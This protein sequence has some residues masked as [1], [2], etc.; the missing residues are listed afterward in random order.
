MVLKC[1]P[2]DTKTSL[3]KLLWKKLQKPQQNPK[4]S[5]IQNLMPRGSESNP[6]L[7]L[8]K[9]SHGLESRQSPHQIPSIPRPALGD[10]SHRTPRNSKP[11][12]LLLSPNSVAS[13]HQETKFQLKTLTRK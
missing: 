9:P 2:S 1:S 10:R 8:P 4:I 6:N 5:L 11:R 7:G 3:I 13:T 12:F